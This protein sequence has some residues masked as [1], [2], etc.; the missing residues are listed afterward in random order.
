MFEC[1]CHTGPIDPDGQ[2]VSGRRKNR[3]SSC[4]TKLKKENCWFITL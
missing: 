1:P 4:R 2:P 3:Y